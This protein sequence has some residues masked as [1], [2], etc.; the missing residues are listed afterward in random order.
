[1]TT[2]YFYAIIKPIN[3][4]G[5]CF[6]GWKIWK[7]WFEGDECQA[8]LRIIAQSFDAAIAEARKVDVRYDTAQVEGDYTYATYN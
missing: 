1:M 3:E 4:T 7:V 2:S 6:M 5:G 8:V